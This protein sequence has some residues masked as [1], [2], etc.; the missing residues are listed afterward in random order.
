MQDSEIHCVFLPTGYCLL[1]TAYCLLPTTMRIG[2]IIH[3]FPCI[4]ETFVVND[5]RGL[6]A[7][8]HE[9]T[10]VALAGADPATIGNPNYQI[11]GKTIRVKGF[12]PPVLR[13]VQKLAAR[14]RLRKRH[15]A[16]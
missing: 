7:L 9:V 4:S 14:Q 2:Y 8:G 15:G 3:S 16:L 11:K 10:A 5:I 12:G 1:P 6:E 13:K